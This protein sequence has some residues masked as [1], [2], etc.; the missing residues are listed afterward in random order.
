MNQK[1]EELLANFRQNPHYLD[2][3]DDEEWKICLA[4]LDKKA[5]RERRERADRAVGDDGDAEDE[6]SDGNKENAV[7]LPI[8]MN[9][10]DRQTE[11]E[12]EGEEEDEGT[13]DPAPDTTVVPVIPKVPTATTSTSQTLIAPSGA[14]IYF[15]HG[16]IN[17][18]LMLVGTDI[19]AAVQKLIE[20]Y[21]AR[22]RLAS[23]TVV[24]INQR[25]DGQATHNTD[26]TEYSCRTCIDK[27]RDGQNYKGYRGCIRHGQKVMGGQLET[28]YFAV[29][30]KRSENQRYVWRTE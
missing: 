21:I 7:A 18:P 28:A 3:H 8:R 11:N 30:Q 13:N 15:F 19:Q 16:N 24:C 6:D 1:R 5:D 20:M 9:T 26:G 25:Y 27:C 29:A 2:L 4:L 14:P 23:N 17:I 12:D 22:G 10:E